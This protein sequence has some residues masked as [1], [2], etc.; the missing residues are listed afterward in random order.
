MSSPNTFPYYA[1]IVE[2]PSVIEMPAE[3]PEV[4]EISSDSESDMIVDSEDELEESSDSIEDFSEDS[5]PIFTCDFCWSRRRSDIMHGLSAILIAE[6]P[7]ACKD[8]I[9]LKI[10]RQQ[11]RLVS[12]CDGCY[13]TW[14]LDLIQNRYCYTRRQVA[15]NIE[16]EDGSDAVALFHT[17]GAYMEIGQDERTF[18]ATVVSGLDAVT[19]IDCHAVANKH[20][21]WNGISIPQTEADYYQ[22]CQAASSLGRDI[23]NCSY[24]LIPGK[25]FLVVAFINLEPCDMLESI[26]EKLQI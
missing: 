18:I 19:K 10:A 6:D 17:I 25:R 22:V 24:T 5:A 12:M 14:M 2:L 13:A 16:N 23:P 1:L 11:G 3:S 20:L 9:L 26:T 21:A 8:P 7:N 4:I 15:L